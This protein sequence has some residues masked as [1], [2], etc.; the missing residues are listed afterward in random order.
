MTATAEEEAF[1]PLS[2]YPG[3]PSEPELADRRERNALI[4]HA[5]VVA[6]DL[7]EQ[8]VINGRHDEARTLRALVLGGQGRK[9]LA[10]V[11]FRAIR[12]RA[13]ERHERRRMP[14]VQNVFVGQIEL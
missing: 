3:A 5:E 11:L 6:P 9:S 1:M 13:H 12:L 10:I 4:Q 14:R 8:G 2:K 7:L